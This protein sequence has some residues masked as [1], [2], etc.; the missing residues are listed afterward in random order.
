L[1]PQQQGY[2]PSPE[3]M[4]AFQMQLERDLQQFGI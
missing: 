2:R 1:A 3:D 4:Q